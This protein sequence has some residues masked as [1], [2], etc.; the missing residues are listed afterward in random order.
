MSGGWIFGRRSCLNCENRTFYYAGVR[1]SV[2][3]IVSGNL[4]DGL[5]CRTL[6]KR[7]D[8]LWQRAMVIAE[9]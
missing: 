3:L 9:A 8:F 1:K 6:T 4:N 5:G 7:S 2:I